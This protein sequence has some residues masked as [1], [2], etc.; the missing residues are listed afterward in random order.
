MARIRIAVTGTQ[1]QVVRSLCE[2]ASGLDIDL[3][4]LGRPVL[5]LAA[6][7]TIAPA[8]KATVADVLVSAAAYTDVNKAESEPALA[9]RVNGEAPGL[10]AGCAHTL[11]MPIIHLSTDYVFDGTKSDPYLE[12]DPINPQSAYGRSKAKGE[13]A[14]AAGN[15]RHVILRTCWVFSPFGRNFVKTMLELAGRQ[16]EVKVVSDQVG[17]PTAA[18]EIAA[19]IL[20]VARNLMDGERAQ[21][22]GTFHLASA[23]AASWAEFATAIFAMAAER[24]HPLA[25]VVPISTAQ[26]PTPAKRPQNSRLDC[27]KIATVH[28]VRIADW[29]NTLRPCIDRILEPAA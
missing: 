3:V 27:S 2:Q 14:V 13:R 15:P 9:D 8:I 23:G 18:A 19:A 1:G 17:N 10:L 29:R 21:H 25:R 26:Y 20:A 11:G 22:Y 16:P 12:T 7:H 24:G 6:P 4:A 5:D 28:G